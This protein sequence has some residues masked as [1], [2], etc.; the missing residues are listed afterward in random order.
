M[1][2]KEALEDLFGRK[3]EVASSDEAPYDSFHG[4][5]IKLENARQEWRKVMEERELKELTAALNDHRTEQR[6]K[7]WTDNGGMFKPSPNSK[8]GN[9][10]SGMGATPLNVDSSGMLGRTSIVGGSAF[11]EKR[12]I[13]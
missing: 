12:R 11:R 6:G 4:K 8:Q 1:G 13:I 3:R 2:I 10:K 9:N 7:M 5:N